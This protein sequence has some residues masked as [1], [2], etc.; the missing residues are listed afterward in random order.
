MDKQSDEDID[1]TCDQMT[2]C[3]A[4]TSKLN[5]KNERKVY[6]KN[7]FERFGDDLAEEV[8]QYLTITDKVRLECVS[9][10]WRRLVYNKQFVIELIELENEGSNS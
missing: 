9:K 2:E 7:T 6:A 3:Q 4:M 8:L 1:N 5:I 10:Q